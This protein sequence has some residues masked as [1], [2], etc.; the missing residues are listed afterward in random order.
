MPEPSLVFVSSEDDRYLV[1]G[2]IGTAIGVLTDAIRDLYPDRRVEWI[3]ESPTAV[4]FR[5][6]EGS[7]TRHYL[8]RK[9]GGAVMPLSRFAR[10]VDGYLRT[11]VEERL[12][13]RSGSGVIIEAADWEGLAA[14]VF[15]NL[16]SDEVLKVSRLHTPLALCAGVNELT[17][18]SADRSQIERE[19]LQLHC[20]DF[21][22]APT[23]FV[24]ANTLETVLN[25]SIEYPP[26]AVIP[27][28][29]NVAGFK[30]S[31][32][33]RRQS[34][35]HLRKATGITLP[36]SAFKV[37]VLG[38]VEIRKGVRIIQEAV[39]KIFD[40]IPDCH[41]VWI[42]HYGASGELT[43]N[44]KLALETFYSGIQEQWRNR[45]HLTGYIDHGE[46]PHV[47]P[48]ADLFAVCYLADN[49]PGVVLEIALSEKPLVALLRGGVPEMIV[50]Q[51]RPLALV[52]DDE[53]PRSI[54]EQLRDA[55]RSHF[56]DPSE[57]RMLAR[58]LRH[59][60]LGRFSPETVTPR[61]LATYDHFLNR[62]RST[63]RPWPRPRPFV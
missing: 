14:G 15:K 37:F 13:D 20:S 59:H 29:A 60:V 24:L 53:L 19:K 40:S 9:E 42:G 7:V 63:P 22:S 43:A 50:D 5:E 12:K 56:H 39:P 55:A 58:E 41:L 46:L 6:Q 44:S 8:S 3:T 11:I 30:P 1:K 10:K 35:D 26:S 18:T 38:S 52:L 49:F 31:K 4:T 25:G 17:L 48:A 21:L 51:D 57:A 32:N 28:C 33:G 62:K 16:T 36:E 27:N 2:G 61:L 23:E 34:L 45:V 54:P 47:L